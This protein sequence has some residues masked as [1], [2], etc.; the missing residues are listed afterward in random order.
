MKY[1]YLCHYFKIQTDFV[2]NRKP[3]TTDF[4]GGFLKAI[5]KEFIEKTLVF[6]ILAVLLAI[7]LV[8]QAKLI[9]PLNIVGALL[10]T[11][12]IASVI[13]LLLVYLSGFR[14]PAAQNGILIWATTITLFAMLTVDCIYVLKGMPAT[15]IAAPIISM[16]TIWANSLY[17]NWLWNI[18][19]PWWWDLKK[20]E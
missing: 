10:L 18:Y 13:S 2:R 6:L 20:I 11:F 16:I 9:T 14:R 15:L 5:K 1:I 3:W 19:K 17:L 4:V 7:V 8:V 12:I